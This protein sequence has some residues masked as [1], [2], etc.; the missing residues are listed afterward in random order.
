MT[1]R[2]F[3]AST[4]LWALALPAAAQTDTSRD[5]TAILAQG[6]ALLAKGDARG[7]AA[8][9]AQALSHNPLSVAGVTLAIDAELAGN[10]TVAAL[11]RYEQWLA[12]RRL[13]DGYALRRIARAMLFEA[14]AARQ[15]NVTARLS[16]LTALAAD[17]D[18]SAAAT[19]E[20][21][22]FAGQFGET[23]ALAEIGDERAVNILVSRLNTMPG[24]KGAIIDALAES[25]SKLAIPALTATLADQNDVNRAA[26]AD[27]LGRMGAMDAVA[28]LRPLLQDPVFSVKLK[29]AGALYRLNDSSGL[30]LLTELT[31][32]E[33]GAIRMAAARELASQ[34][35]T[36]WQGLV[37]SLASDPDPVVRLDAA[38]L[39]APYDLALAKQ[40]IDELM[41]NDN[42][43]VREAASTVLVERVAT[44]FATLRAL[45]HSSDIVVRVKAADRILE[46]TR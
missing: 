23:R 11:G 10:G 7:A 12:T 40:V 8:S 28:Q 41:R 20:K 44:D 1:S 16:A 13:D 37:R 5:E 35:D 38:R 42:I 19:L 31:Q 29:A 39:I 36:V 4:L 24:N 27:A 3:I 2:I 15:P 45:L 26:A 33:H 6:W 22:A 14:V 30:S 32:S 17:G 34:P 25:G 46:L 9:A 18:R 21:A 43:A